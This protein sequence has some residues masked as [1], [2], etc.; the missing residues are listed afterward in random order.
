MQC[1]C[2]NSPELT[3]PCLS[4][5]KTILLF[6]EKQNRIVSN[7]NVFV[8]CVHVIVREGFPKM[9]TYLRKERLEEVR[10]SNAGSLVIITS[11]GS[12]S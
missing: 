10:C 5:S 11:V 12:I 9:K 8:I 4:A 3:L 2:E 1:E 6:E 7:S